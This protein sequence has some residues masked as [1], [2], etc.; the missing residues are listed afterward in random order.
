MYMCVHSRVRAHD[1]PRATLLSGKGRGLPRIRRG[2]IRFSTRVILKRIKVTFLK[3]A[4][5]SLSFSSFASAAAF[6]IRRLAWA[7]AHASL[8]CLPSCVCVSVRACVMQ[9][10]RGDRL[11]QQPADC[12]RL[13]RRCSATQTLAFSRYARR[14]VVRLRCCCVLHCMM[15]RASP[16]EPTPSAVSGIRENN[17]YRTTEHRPRPQRTAFPAPLVFALPK[18][19]VDGI[20]SFS[21]ILARKP[22]SPT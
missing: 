3:T 15:R 20:T 11:R 21:P 6:C 16:T 5:S 12:G 2:S 17:E 14:C 8:C 10:A 9:M 18:G 1:E 4:A 22:A 19:L 7:S 13:S